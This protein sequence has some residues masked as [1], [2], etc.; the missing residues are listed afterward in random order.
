MQGTVAVT[1]A[2]GFIGHVF[3]RSLVASKWQVRALTRRLQPD[4]DPSVEWIRGDLDDVDALQ[5][6]VAGS[7][8]VVHCAG[9]VRGSS[10]AQFDRTNV[11][12]TAN[13]VQI[14]TQQ[15]LP[16][17]FLLISSLA[18]KHPNLSWYAC[19]KRK[20]EQILIEHAQGMQW[21]IFRPTAV[22]GP[23]DRE[24][25]PLFRMSKYGFLIMPG[26]AE[27]RFSL[28]HVDDLAAALL[29][30][31]SATACVPGVFELADSKSEGYDRHA[32]AAIAE[33]V[34]GR[35]V[36]VLSL[37]SLLIFF[38]AYLN[39]GAA[40]VCRYSPMLTPGKVRELLHQD[41][42]CDNTNLKQSLPDWQPRINLQD[43][44]PNVI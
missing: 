26:L 10:Q 5:K 6:L 36:W 38:A 14:C 32:L 23:G 35:P 4:D 20:A 33:H 44:L 31:L 29:C 17:R 28:L 16:P 41:W 22:Y 7:F 15:D 34:W 40:L 43:A 37:P 1:G 42:L 30:W 19:S 2:T 25:K 9:T 11:A 24:L 3:L 18:A 39:L 13:L 27:S 8:A 12:G 21:S